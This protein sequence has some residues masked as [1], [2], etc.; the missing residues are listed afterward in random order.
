MEV[1][2]KQRRRRR[3]E[4]KKALVRPNYTARAVEKLREQVEAGDARATIAAVNACLHAA[5][6]PPLWLTEKY[7]AP[8]N[9]W[10]S[11]EAATLDEAFGI[12]RGHEQAEVQQRNARLRPFVVYRVLKLRAEGVKPRRAVFAKVAEELRARVDGDSESTGAKVEA[13]YGEPASQDWEKFFE[14]IRRPPSKEL[15]KLKKLRVALRRRF[16]NRQKT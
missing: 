7:I 16:Q 5:V 12:Q 8:V 4:K 6:L 14:A 3:N 2:A 15:V 10:L 9:K 13:I 11:F 1:P